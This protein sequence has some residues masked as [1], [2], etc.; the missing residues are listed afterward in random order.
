[1][2][3][4][5]IKK[6]FKKDQKF[7]LIGLIIIIGLI[8]YRL[9]IQTPQNIDLKVV[10]STAAPIATATP[11]PTPDIKPD[12]FGNLIYTNHTDNYSFQIPKDWIVR[13][14]DGDGKG[15]L[16]D[17]IVP[18]GE[19]NKKYY[20]TS[21][22]VSV[23]HPNKRTEQ[24][25]VLKNQ[26]DFDKRYNSPISLNTNQRSYKVGNT[27]VSGQKAI[28]EVNKS[29]QGDATDTFYKLVT[30]FYYGIAQVNISFQFDQDVINKNLDGYN[31]ILKTFKLLGP[32]PTLTPVF[33]KTYTN[34]KLGY[35]FKYPSNWL[36]NSFQN[37]DYNKGITIV[38]EHDWEV[39]TMYQEPGSRAG[40]SIPTEYKKIQFEA[41]LVNVLFDCDH[42]RVKTKNGQEFR[43][44]MKFFG[45]PPEAK[46]LELLKTVQGLTIVN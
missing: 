33:L 45:Y 38:D 11:K 2:K 17:E 31:L 44:E 35:S 42:P 29:L 4:K 13:Q 12:S 28:T 39:I 16:F 34:D 5:F 46:A 14:F 21:V 23:E 24:E 9:Q 41:S 37:G 8:F 1:M 15:H 3:N 10:K 22:V 26:Q 25:E 36:V 43:F 40:C 19:Q 7:L 30:S 20:S 18:P 32:V 6:S 27:I